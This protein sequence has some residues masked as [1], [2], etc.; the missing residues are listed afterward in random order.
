M[1]STTEIG[2]SR[3]IAAYR[4][5]IPDGHGMCE[6]RAPSKQ[7]KLNSSVGSASDLRKHHNAT[8]L[9]RKDT[10]L[11]CGNRRD[12][13]DESHGFYASGA[14][15]HPRDFQS[16][17]RA[18]HEY[19]SWDPNDGSIMVG[20][21]LGAGPK[22]ERPAVRHLDLDVAECRPQDRFVRRAMRDASRRVHFFFRG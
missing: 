8:A 11:A 20:I 16:K 17:R 19:T 12:D 1:P 2:A 14:N 4:S 3:T 6:T 15:G 21:N 22:N 18:G 9:A 7:C 13:A 5:G 10:K